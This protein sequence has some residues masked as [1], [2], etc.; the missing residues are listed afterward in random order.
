MT[1]F[2]SLLLALVIF[3]ITLL[4]LAWPLAARMPLE[5]AEK[6]AATVALSLLG[7]FLAGWAVYVLALP[8]RWLW[9]LPGLAVAGLGFNARSFASS[10]REPDVRA[11]AAG[12]LAVAG[13]C[14][15]WLLLVVSYSGGGWAADW[16]E[17]WER[18]QFFVHAG[19]PD[20]RFVGRYPLTARPPLANVVTATFLQLTRND[21]AHY[22]YFS[23]LLASLVFLPGALLARRLG[24]GTR[25]VGLVALLF[26]LNPLFLQNAT[27]P[28]TK[29]PAAFFVLTGFYFFLRYHGE[30]ASSSSV[31]AIL[32]GACLAAALLTHYSS[33][34]YVL[35]LAIG[36]LVRGWPQRSEPGW[37]QATVRSAGSGAAV[38]AT[39][40]GWTFATYGLRGT[41]LSNSSVTALKAE[42]GSWILKI[43]LNL[44]DT[45]V[46][47]FLRPLDTTL[48]AQA[49]FWGRTRD[50]FFQLFQLNLFFACGS[51]AWLAMVVALVPAWRASTRFDRR[52]W[53]GSGVALV[54]IGVGVHGA[55]DTWG[56]THIC[57][58]PLI[59][60]GL[61]FL[62]AKWA[63]LGRAWRK[64]VVAGAILDFALGI[65]LHFAVQNQSPPA[66]ASPR[67]AA[68]F[69]S[70]YNEATAM[71]Y[72]A[73]LHHQLVFL[74]DVFTPPPTLVL[75]LLGG[76][77]IFAGIL[78]RAPTRPAN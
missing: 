24:G 15:G 75:A 36:W 66:F 59:L 2:P 41:L 5:S 7:V 73:K 18:A 48:I 27:F 46:P 69:L 71:N 40:F 3:A 58:Q 28:W 34:P 45:L 47:H 57:L 62:A 68:E 8:A 64:L 38:L 78:A 55:R 22:Q 19:A 6:M 61:A 35:I 9:A 44:R 23:T 16:F 42:Q 65:G 72:A 26:M 29:L 43:A 67:S 56:L 1:E 17:H 54:L 39:W 76:L 51:V 60:L 52:W 49:S 12:Q 13:W 63:S 74:N 20:F 32:T 37:L 21:F 50:E 33:G 31:T 10:L 4:G 11:L 77:L 30:R 70:A 53:L 14:V 25:G